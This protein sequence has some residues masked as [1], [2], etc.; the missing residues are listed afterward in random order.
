M[1]FTGRGKFGIDSIK[2]SQGSIRNKYVAGSG[3]GATSSFARRAKLYRAVHKV[4]EAPAPPPP[5]PIT[6]LLNIIATYLRNYMVEFRNTNF[7]G[8]KM[9][10]EDEEGEGSN[11]RNTYIRDGGKDMFDRGMYI[12]PW[13]LSGDSFDLDST[14][15]EAYPYIIQYDTI[16]ETIVDTNLKYISL[17]YI[18]ETYTPE[19][20]EQDT[21]EPQIDQSLHPLTILCYRD[22]GPVGWQNGGEMGADGY[23][24][25]IHGYVYENDILNGFSVY[26]GYRQVYNTDRPPGSLHPEDPGSSGDPTIC[27]LVILLG[28][29]SWGSVFGPV[30]LI[31]DDEDLQDCKFVMY[32]G[33]GSA[34]ILAINVLLSK[35]KDYDSEPIPDSELQTIISNYT[36][37]IKEACG[38]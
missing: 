35:G 34:N 19:E 2:N 6:G 3:V 23:G 10:G 33:E 14:Y 13:L 9:D 16:T 28:H 15:I 12:T 5:P 20:Y 21:N 26:A 18:P 37:R 29:P 25:A 17:G 22:S 4:E 27:Q 7:W 24:T 8:Y 32:S 36:I 1:I 38:L 11:T 30:T 31:S